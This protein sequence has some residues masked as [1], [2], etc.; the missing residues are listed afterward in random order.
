MVYI[1]GHITFNIG[2]FLLVYYLFITFLQIA[3]SLIYKEIQE[4]RL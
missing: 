2:N 3:I 4:N 1:V